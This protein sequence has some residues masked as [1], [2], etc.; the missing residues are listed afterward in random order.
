M[1]IPNNKGQ[2]KPNF[3]NLW[4]QAMAMANGLGDTKTVAVLA[5]HKENPER[6]C[7]KLGIVCP[8]DIER[9]K[10][11]SSTKRTR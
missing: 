11:S 7:R 2:I 4:T 10:S 5:N 6:I 1:A 9:I 3:K 8:A